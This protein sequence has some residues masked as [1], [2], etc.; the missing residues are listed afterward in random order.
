MDTELATAI[1]NAF[2]PNTTVYECMNAELMLEKYKLSEMTLAAFVAEMY[3][4]EGIRADRDGYY[5]EWLAS[6]GE[7][8]NRLASIPE[9]R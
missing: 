3:R 2:G 5:S 4:W 8:S 1:L 6:A 7:V 9:L